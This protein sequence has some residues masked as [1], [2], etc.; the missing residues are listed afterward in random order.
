MPDFCMTGC[1]EPCEDRWFICVK[2]TVVCPVMSV[3]VSLDGTPI[4][5]GTVAGTLGGV[6]VEVPGPGTYQVTVSGVCGGA[7]G[8]ECERTFDVE[9]QECDPTPVELSPCIPLGVIVVCGG[10][11]G[12]IE[13][14]SVTLTRLPDELEI[15]PKTTNVDG[16][17]LFYVCLGTSY[18]YLVDYDDTDATVSGTVLI[19]NEFG[20]SVTVDVCEGGGFE[21]PCCDDPI[22]ETL[23]VTLGTGAMTPVGG[24]CGGTTSAFGTHAGTTH[25]L[26]YDAGT[27]TWR[28]T[29]GGNGMSAQCWYNNFFLDPAIVVASVELIYT[30]CAGF[31]EEPGGAMPYGSFTYRA[32]WS[33][34]AGGQTKYDVTG[35]GDPSG[36][37]CPPVAEVCNTASATG[38]GAAIANPIATVTE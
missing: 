15:G 13:G 26:T 25:T 16:V 20:Q 37:S 31:S 28:A 22:P 36:S 8:H 18:E 19:D 5:G 32:N 2:P 34:S 24:L 10:E 29:L 4:D 14:A 1:C 27:S 6:C 12:E 30:P 9:A 23:S 3:E 33:A 38:A 21:V 17:A 35:N 11:G 7:P